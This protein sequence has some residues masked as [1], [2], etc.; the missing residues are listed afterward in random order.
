MSAAF[1]F[2]VIVGGANALGALLLIAIGYDEDV[3]TTG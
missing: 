1:W 2:F 3:R